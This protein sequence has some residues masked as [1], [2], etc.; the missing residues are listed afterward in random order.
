MYV[1]VCLRERESPGHRATGRWAQ[2][3]MCRA[4]WEASGLSCGSVDF[5]IRCLP[6]NGLQLVGNS[7]GERICQICLEGQELRNYRKTLIKMTFK[8]SRGNI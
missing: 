7:M 3:E 2:W 8:T 4:C 6:D 1:C 5:V